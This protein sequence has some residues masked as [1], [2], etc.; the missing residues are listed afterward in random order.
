[1][2]QRHRGKKH[3]RIQKVR[4]VWPEGHLIIDYGH[5]SR[6]GM[7]ADLFCVK[8]RL[9]ERESIGLTD[10]PSYKTIFL[11]IRKH[12]CGNNPNVHR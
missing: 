8:T 2:G 12:S 3:Y 9:D 5:G 1:M 11:H 6:E 7:L 4:G 10:I